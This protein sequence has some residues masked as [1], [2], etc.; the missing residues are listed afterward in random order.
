MI[1]LVQTIAESRGVD[2]QI[3]NGWWEKFWMRNPSITFLRASVPLSKARAEATDSEIYFDLLEKT[4]A[5][6]DLLDK[7]CQVFNADESGFPL[8]PKPLKAVHCSGAHATN[9]V[10]SGD[11]TQIT[12][13]ACVSAGGHSIPP[14]VIWDRKVLSPELASGEIPG[15]I[16]G[17]SNKGDRSR[18]I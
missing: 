2:R 1:A 5:E 8:A 9:A 11:K 15:M 18:T 12:V 16:Y 4:M 17:L 7:P 14:F 10:N 13:L 3:S 6:H